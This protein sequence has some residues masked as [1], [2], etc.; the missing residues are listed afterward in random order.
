MNQISNVSTVAIPYIGQ[1]K[2]NQFQT[3]IDKIKQF[4]GD[5][6]KYQQLLVADQQALNNAQTTDDFLKVSAQI[7][8][9]IA[10]TTVSLTQ[11][12][13][14]SLLQ[15]FQSEGKNWCPA[16]QY[17]APLNGQNYPLDYEYDQQGI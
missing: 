5:V 9:D 10:S 17:H 6:T 2:I 11:A 1:I 7:D 15:Q 16:H 13:A 14:N 4:G 3:D 8:K 12:Q